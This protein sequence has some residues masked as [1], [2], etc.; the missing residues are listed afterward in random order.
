MPTVLNTGQPLRQSAPIPRPSALSRMLISSELA[1]WGARAH[2]LAHLVPSQQEVGIAPHSARQTQFL[3]CHRSCRPSVKGG[4]TATV[5]LPA[6]VASDVTQLRPHLRYT[7]ARLPGRAWLRQIHHWTLQRH[8]GSFRSAG[9][10]SFL[11]AHRIP[12]VVKVNDD[13]CLKVVD[14]YAVQD[15]QGIIAAATVEMLQNFPGSLSDSAHRKG[16]LR[17]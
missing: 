6:V 10:G 16:P 8:W 13:F 17:G 5:E 3:P 14:Q 12:G 2:V 15:P 9:S 7:V 4:H 1:S 11:G